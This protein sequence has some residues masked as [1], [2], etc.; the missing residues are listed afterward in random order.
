M[1]RNNSNT[2]HLSPSFFF[3]LHA[4]PRLWLCTF[5]LS[6]AVGAVLLL[7]I[8]IL[9]N[10]VL[11]TFPHNYYMQWLNGSLIHGTQKHTY[12]LTQTNTWNTSSCCALGFDPCFSRK[13]KHKKWWLTLIGLFF[14]SFGIRPADLDWHLCVIISTNSHNQGVSNISSSSELSGKFRQY[15]QRTFLETFLRMLVFTL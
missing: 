12:A 11:L 7:P 14:F 8:S 9:S 2:H 5:T 3:F 6:V 1:G 4:H 15:V 10:E 13:Q